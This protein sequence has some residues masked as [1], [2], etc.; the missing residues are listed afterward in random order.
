M[1]DDG[2]ILSLRVHVHHL[3]DS[4]P[5]LKQGVA[6]RVAVARPFRVVELDHLQKKRS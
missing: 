5:E 3:S 1:D 6:E 4:S 2:A